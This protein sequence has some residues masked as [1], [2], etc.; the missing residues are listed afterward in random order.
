[1]K[2]SFTSLW[3]ACVV[4]LALSSGAA[5]SE[6]SG[7]TLSLAE[8]VKIAVENNAVVKAAEEN[9]KGAE[10]ERLEARADRLPKMSASYSYTHLADAPFMKGARMPPTPVAHRNQ[11]HWD[12]TVV[13]PL[14]TG[15][16]LTSRYEMTKLGVK[17]KEKEREEAVLDVAKGAKSAY[18][19]A[20]LTQ[21]LLLVAE[22][23][24][25]S[26][27]SHER[28]TQRFYD[29]GVIRLNDLL[30]ARV[31]LANA[32]QGR[33]KAKASARMSL[34]DLNRWL[35]FDIHRS[36]RIEDIETAP[37]NAD[38]LEEM[39]REGIENRPLLQALHLSLDVL[40]KA[41]RME[42]SAYYPRVALIGGYQRDGNDPLGG[43]NDYGNDHNAWLA[44]EAK[45]TFYDSNKTKSRVHKAKAD[46]SAFL[47]TIR[48][49]EDGV[50]LEI[51]H[52]RLDLEVAEKNI[53]TA[54]ASLTQAKENLRITRLG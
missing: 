54:K 44:V 48:R 47:Q 14:F 23:A 26:L 1:M 34:A 12:L 7:A 51:I 4:C 50:R 32:I 13:Q 27:R 6:S 22:D 30:R 16:A 17:I 35:A 37:A 20:L 25:T 18:F 36:T 2:K 46:K 45:W 15:F 24:I 42:E 8:A 41:I 11:H 31:A 39:T 28:D 21:K 49:V 3:I 40:D 38:P 53:E 29:R 19:N 43:N 52:A 5:G 33:E 9:L 10:Y